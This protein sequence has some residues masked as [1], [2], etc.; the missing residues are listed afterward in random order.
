MYTVTITETRPVR[1]ILPKTW[2]VV[3]GAT[4]TAP[5]EYGHTPEVETIATE[6]IERYTQNVE[7]LNLDAVIKAV[8][9]RKR[10]RTAKQK[11]LPI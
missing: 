8:N 6:T 1:K 3:K 11:E 10:V 2:A 5:A 9:K 4:E 7:E